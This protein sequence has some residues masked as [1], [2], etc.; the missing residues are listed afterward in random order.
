MVVPGGGAVSYERGTTAYR[1]TSLVRPR[2]SSA[3][4]SKGAGTCP[5]ATEN[6]GPY[7]A[8]VILPSYVS[9]EVA[10]ELETLGVRLKKLVF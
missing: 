1:D 5:C 4:M 6:P 3:M 7:L 8:Q 10:W 2:P 9:L